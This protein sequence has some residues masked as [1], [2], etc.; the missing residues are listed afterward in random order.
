MRDYQVAFTR[1]HETVTVVA[2]IP[3]LQIADFGIDPPAA[4][5]R[6]QAMAAFHLDCLAQEGKPIP[7]EE[8]EEA[9]FSLRVRLPR[10]PAA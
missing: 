9:G 5:D 2:G 7:T 3:A 6:L 10:H 8:R 4:L 1:D